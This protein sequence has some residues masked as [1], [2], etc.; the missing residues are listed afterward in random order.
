MAEQR[1]IYEKHPELFH[2]TSWDGVKGILT[3]Q[4]LWATHYTFLNDAS[5]IQLMRK[6]L[7]DRLFPFMR[8]QV[9]NVYRGA[10]QSIRAKMKKAGGTIAIARD[11]AR[12]LTETIYKTA[13]EDTRVGPAIAVPYITSFCAHTSDDSYERNNGLLSQWRGY[14]KGGYA[15][16]FATKRLVDLYLR[17]SK[18]FYYASGFLGDVVYQH[19]KEAFEEE[20]GDSIAKIQNVFQKFI[21]TEQWE[22]GEIFANCLSMFTRLKHRAFYEEREVRAISFPMTKEI[23]NSHKRADPAYRSP[24]KPMKKILRRN[25]GALYIETLNID[26]KIRLPIKRIIIGPQENMQEKNEILE[27]MVEGRKIKIHCSETP[28]IWPAG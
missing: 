19:D 28:L 16:V 27:K 11:E 3:S 10:G 12:H 20:F 14:A 5:E 4:N 6:E 25:D 8:E 13:F 22:V 21:E 2:Y 17:E 18:K 1:Q 26:K 7:S 9:V 15:I 23:E 24:S